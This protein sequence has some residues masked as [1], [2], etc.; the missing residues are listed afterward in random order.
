MLA[1]MLTKPLQGEQ[2]RAFRDKLLGI[3]WVLPSF[4]F[5]STY[6]LPT[7]FLLPWPT[8]TLCIIW[9]CFY[10]S[11]IPSNSFCPTTSTSKTWTLKT[12]TLEPTPH[13]VETHQLKTHQDEDSRTNIP[14]INYFHPPTLP[15]TTS[16]YN[17]QFQPPTISTAYK[18]LQPTTTTFFSDW[19]RFSRHRCNIP[20]PLKKLYLWLILNEHVWINLVP[21]K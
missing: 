15:K 16:S 14:T 12:P 20:E 6:A 2:F 1:D 4:E 17:R 19:D 9:I 18:F 11:A 10:E 8:S 5:S 7:L 3:T 21:L 13:M